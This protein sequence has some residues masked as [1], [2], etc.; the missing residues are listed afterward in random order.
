MYNTK[1]LLLW[2]QDTNI[3]RTNLIFFVITNT[4]NQILKIFVKNSI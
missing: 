3:P 4:T 2:Q 1:T